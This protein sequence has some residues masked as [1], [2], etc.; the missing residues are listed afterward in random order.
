MTCNAV[1]I[2]NFVIGE[3]F[4]TFIIA[5]IG[6][7]HNGDLNRA[8]QLITAAKNAGADAVKFQSFKAEKMCD[9]HL[10]ETK[11]VEGVTG[12]SNSSFDMY[13]ALE[14]SDQMHYELL[15]H[16]ID[17]GIMFLSSVF[18]EQTAD[19]LDALDVPAY[20]IA[21][22]DLTHLPLIEHVAKK[23]KPVV[24][25]T[26][27]ATMADVTAAVEVCHKAGNEQVVILHCVS[28]YP[29]PANDL[30]LRAIQTMQEELPHPVGYSDHFE[31]SLAC[32][33]AVGMGALVI[34]KHFT[35]DNEW[36]GPD[37]RISLTADQFA[38]C[39]RSIRLIESMRGSGIKLPAGSEKDAIVSSRRSI[40]VLGSISA[41]EVITPDKIIML[42][43]EIGLAPGE[44]HNV[45]GRKAKVDLTNHAPISWS[46]VD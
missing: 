31:G 21:S 8:K 42:K 43:P 25:S 35:L 37:H 41:G 12:G 11:D 22:S 6:I 28:S 36:Q 20:K 33:A 5:E 40:R 15:K 39:V 32:I 27:L 16:A 2:G 34:E 1:R 4:P 7:N 44:I 17:E 10:T 24:I 46:V 14:V 3:G 9:M 45:I 13:K 38:Q 30:N 29:P 23:G 26:G 18:D 19:F